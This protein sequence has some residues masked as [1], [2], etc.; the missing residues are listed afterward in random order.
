MRLLMCISCIDVRAG[1][2]RLPY[3]RQLYLS[4][5]MKVYVKSFGSN[6]FTEHKTKIKYMIRMPSRC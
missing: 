3:V 1:F 2:K 4:V 5:G 6:A